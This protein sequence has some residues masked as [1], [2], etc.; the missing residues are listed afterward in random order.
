MINLCFVLKVASAFTLATHIIAKRAVQMEDGQ[1][2][3]MYYLNDG[4]YG[5]FN[6]TIFDHW[7]VEPTPII[8]NGDGMNCMEMRESHLTTLWGPT[9]DSMDCIK[10]DV[11]LPEMHIGE[12]IIFREM[13]A[14]TMCAGSTF[15]G[16]KLPSIKY[17]VPGYTL[18]MLQNLPNWP[19]IANVL[20]I[21]DDESSIDAFDVDH[22]LEIIPV[23]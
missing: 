19:R 4:V 18:E 14:Y 13:G 3:M 11:H 2:A 20:D 5:S 10:R 7:E 21:H 23:H 22:H 8:V 6:C 1:I 17:H 9:C 12:W 15:N 16:F